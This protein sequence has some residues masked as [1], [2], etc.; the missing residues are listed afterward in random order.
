MPSIHASFCHLHVILAVLPLGD[1][2][3]SRQMD[4]ALL[5]VVLPVL[6]LALLAAVVALLA[7]ALELAPSRTAV[8][9]DLWVVEDVRH[10]RGN[11]TIYEAMLAKTASCA[12]VCLE[13][14]VMASCRRAVQRCSTWKSN[15]P[16]N[17]IPCGVGAVD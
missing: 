6:H 10:G 7:F 16:F 3:L 17:E 1:P 12:C 5:L 13:R 11:K 4:G 14:R 15:A 9:A 8:L 2:D